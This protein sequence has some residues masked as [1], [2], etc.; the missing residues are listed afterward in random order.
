EL[1][2]ELARRDQNQAPSGGGNYAPSPSNDIHDLEAENYLLKEI[3][4]A[5]IKEKNE[6]EKVISALEK[7][8]QQQKEE[9]EE[10]LTQSQRSIENI[11]YRLVDSCSKCL[12]EEEEVK[13]NLDKAK[14]EIF[15]LCDRLGVDISSPLRK[16]IE[17]SN[18][19][20]DLLN[21]LIKIH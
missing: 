21:N 18:T 4:E 1:R 2:E 6:L 14:K 20:K 9:F 13:E 17:K 15:Q 11:E 19:Y 12:S 3:N 5:L 10:K 8:K 7:E 16:N